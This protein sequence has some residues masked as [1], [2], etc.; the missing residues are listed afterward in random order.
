MEA[1]ATSLREAMFVGAPCISSVCGSV[2][3]FMHH[4]N[5]S[6]LYRYDEADVLASEIIYLFNNPDETIS[7]AKNGRENIRKKYRQDTFNLVDI[8]NK[9]I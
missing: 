9:I 7:I 1:Q 2:L 3:D 5:D 6:M 8:Y 4:G